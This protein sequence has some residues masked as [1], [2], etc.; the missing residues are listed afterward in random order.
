MSD[1]DAKLKIGVDASEMGPAAEQTKKLGDA[2]A[3]VGDAGADASGDLNKTAES[4][5]KVEAAE[6]GVTGTSQQAAN[7]LEGVGAAAAES[8]QTAVEGA[9]G[10]ARALEGVTVAA[11]DER[12]ALLAAGEAAQQSGAETKQALDGV[13]AAEE[14]AAGGARALATETKKVGEAS[15]AFKN[16]I[17]QIEEMAG[18]IRA[19]GA[20]LQIQRTGIEQAISATEDLVRGQLAMGESGQA[21][22]QL[23]TKALAGLKTQLGQIDT[24]LGAVAAA[25][26]RAGAAG[27]SA[28]GETA[29]AQG[30]V[31]QRIAL[32]EAAVQKAEKQFIT[33]GQIEK[34]AVREVTETFEALQIAIEQ[35]AG[36]TAAATGS[37][38]AA[39]ENLRGKQEQI[40]AT[41]NRL[42][43]ATKDNTIALQEG[44]HQIAGVANAAQNLVSVFDMQQITTT[45]LIGKTGSLAMA[46]GSLKDS[47]QVMDLNTIKA[48]ASAA[49]FGSQLGLV[50]AAT[51]AATLAGKKLAETNSQNAEVMDDMANAAK[52]LGKEALADTKDQVSGLQSAFTSIALAGG[53]LIRVMGEYGD[54]SKESDKASKELSAAIDE[55]T[56]A[57]RVGAS[58][59]KLYNIARRDGLDMERAYALALS[60]SAV[61]MKFYEDSRRGGAEGQR[62]WSQ[63]L[64]ESQGDAR[65]LSEFIARNSAEMTRAIKVTET[66]TE[67]QRENNKATREGINLAQIKADT[68]TRLLGAEEQNVARL[69]AANRQLEQAQNGTT[70]SLNQGLAAIRSMIG[71]SARNSEELKDMAGALAEVLANTSDLSAKERERHATVIELALRGNDL[72]ASEREYAAALAQSIINGD[73]AVGTM[74]AREAAALTLKTAIDDLVSATAAESSAL[75]ANETAIERAVKS[76]EKLLA[77]NTPLDAIER[78]RLSTI[79]DL[80]KSVGELAAQQDRLT[81][82]AASTAEAENAS[83][84]AESS[85]IL[86]KSGKVDVIQREIDARAEMIK[87]LSIEKTAT[88]EVTKSTQGSIEVWKGGQLIYSNVTEEQTKAAAAIKAGGDAAE[89][90]GKQFGDLLVRRLADGRVVITQVGES[91]VE[92][93]DNLSR[94]GNRAAEAGPAVAGAFEKWKGGVGNVDEVIDKIRILDELF[95]SLEERPL[96]IAENVAVMG[97]ALEKAGDS[98]TKASGYASTKVQETG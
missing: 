39:L 27:S 77:S 9:Q 66:Q 60:D 22:A 93:A 6:E 33:S 14:Q 94:I 75:D 7:A 69:S 71:D 11:G 26:A 59:V 62:L 48:G 31:A 90:A 29:S 20:D 55:V 15:G 64:R 40:N 21:N 67:A 13:T 86:I 61:V 34:G 95:A 72:T 87:A 47:V 17:G 30:L 24:E 74:A 84:E 96:R 89:N 97:K 45:A 2:L 83:G 49:K 82:A 46:Y 56:L 12:G 51:I 80:G 76:A 3:K 28:A 37:Q 98:A 73:K 53:E 19:S 25:H 88:D 92:T 91:A 16:L 36:T 32:V 58:G 68:T 1:R 54:E 63:A 38:V 43:N 41:A 81:A 57:Y 44:E 50:I 70:A 35:T 10:A 5:G 65:L 4:L 85:L 79:V 18:A 78:A 42:T 8:S 52:R 23:A